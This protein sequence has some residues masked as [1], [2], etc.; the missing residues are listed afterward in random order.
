MKSTK[1]VSNI[2]P[3]FEI[4]TYMNWLLHIGLYRRKTNRIN[5]V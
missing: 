3:V 1:Y 4:E 2:G 5:E